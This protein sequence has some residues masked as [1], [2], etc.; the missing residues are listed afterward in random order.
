MKVVKL[1]YDQESDILEVRFAVGKKGDR[2]GI[3]INEDI[4]LFCDH[5]FSELHGLT[6]LAYSKLISLPPQ[7]LT[8]LN[9]APPII[10]EKVRNLLQ[11]KN[12]QPFLSLENGDVRLHDVRVKQL[13]A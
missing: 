12:L 4:T 1:S 9:E 7:P 2:T 13:A 3:G 11:C 8:E 10:Q 5:S 6:I